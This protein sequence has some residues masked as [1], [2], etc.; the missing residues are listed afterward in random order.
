MGVV[1]FA[2]DHE[3]NY[4]FAIKT[5]QDKYLWH[6]DLINLFLKEATIWSRF[7]FHPNLTNAFL[8]EKIEGK[9]LIFIE[10]VNLGDLNQFIGKIDILK[11][12]DFAIQICNGMEY[13][14]NKYN[15]VHRDIKPGNLLIQEDVRSK[16]GYCIKITDFG[17]VGILGEDIIEGIKEEIT[18]V[19]SGKGTRVYMPP[20]QFSSQIKNNFAFEGKVTTKSDIYS[21]GVTLYQLITGK[22]PFYNIKDIFTKDPDNPKDINNEITEELN[23]IIM[24]CIQKNPNERYDN[25]FE[26]KKDLIDHHN[27]LTGTKYDLLAQEGELTYIGLNIKGLSFLNLGEYK[28]AI[29]YF[30]KSLKLNPDYPEAWNNKGS[31]FKELG[32]TQKA[33]YC[34]N[35][36]ITID[37][38]NLGALNNKGIIL[39]SLGEYNK[40]LSLFNKAIDINSNLAELWMNKGN[41][42][43]LLEKRQKA[44]YCYKEASR[45]DPR[46]PDIWY[47]QGMVLLSLKSHL[48]SEKAFDQSLKINPRY[49]QSYNYKGIINAEMGKYQEAI[50]NFD[51]AIKIKKNLVE[52]W[53]NKGNTFRLM[54]EY[55]KALECL[56]N[57]LRINSEYIKA[58]NNKGIMF[59][60]LNKLP[61]ALKCY[62]KALKIDKNSYEAGMGKGNVLR[63]MGKNQ[64]ALNCFNTILKLYPRN[65]NALY[66]KFL[67]Y[68]SLK[69]NRKALK[70]LFILF[71]SKYFRSN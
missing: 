5:F 3:K 69:M 27:H 37:S 16:Y 63:L 28:E 46:N 12:L 15:I 2:Y 44:L 43:D 45:I 61:E 7:G 29:E 26:L 4:N 55:P 41:I 23:S 34:Y 47:N 33:L 56:N 32:N 67:I 68:N 60:E 20:E 58:Y 57:A 64:E 13:V 17:L 71:I 19:S 40:A 49:F 31:A 18:H 51:K 22:L 36:A 14:H 21:F 6:D 30:N 70:Y 39:M 50:T 8:V 48:D 11:S 38:S 9:P 53:S 54:G 35:K 66:G 1:Y 52:A 62:N 65:Y 10:Y 42:F 25:F 59:I 24:K